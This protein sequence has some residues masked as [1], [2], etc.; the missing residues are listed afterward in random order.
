MQTNTLWGYVDF[1][2]AVFPASHQGN[3]PQAQADYPA[4]VGSGWAA[5]QCQ[6]CSGSKSESGCQSDKNMHVPTSI[7]VPT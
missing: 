1:D 5:S 4:A 7:H 2:W 6:H 3:Y